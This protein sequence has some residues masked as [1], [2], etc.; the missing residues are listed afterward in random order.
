MID[1]NT[2]PAILIFLKEPVPGQ[3]KTR[4]ARD[5]GEKAACEI[6]CQMVR[7]QLA[8]LPATWQVEIHFAPASARAAF[9]SWLGSAY[10]YFPQPEGDLGRRLRIATA[11]AFGRGHK[12]VILIGGDCP[13]LGADDLNETGRLLAD[14]ADVVMGPATD[15]GY[16][17]LGLRSHP[18]VLPVFE[19]IPWSTSEVARVTLDRIGAIG[20][21]L[22]QLEEKEDVDD[23]AA[24]HRA[25][26]AGHL[27]VEI[28]GAEG[29]S[30]FRPS[31]L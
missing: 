1:A 24:Y 16:Y 28:P 11:A 25:T 3:V 14:G 17:L 26:A 4:L 30:R 21:R 18:D 15:G 22:V 20:L 29:T 7:R 2:S 31:P 27:E 5:L 8:A 23:L 19:E 13:A 9:L 10:N 6:Y 12:N